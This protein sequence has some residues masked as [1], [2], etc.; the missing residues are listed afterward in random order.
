MEVRTTQVR[1]IEVRFP[2]VHISEVN[3]DV[4]TFFP[5]L[6]PNLDPLLKLCEMFWIPHE[7]NRRL[8]F[9]GGYSP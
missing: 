1:P 2:E 5:P 7:V 8:R 6:I 9:P 4:R 3:L